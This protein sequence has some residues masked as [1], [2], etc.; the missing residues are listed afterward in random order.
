MT[1]GTKDDARIRDLN[2]LDLRRY[3]Y[4]FGQRDS[5]HFPIA[6]G[7]GK[8]SIHMFSYPTGRGVHFILDTNKCKESEYLTQTDTTPH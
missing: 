5:T 8:G 3:T 4:F 1:V 7:G 2:G 6:I